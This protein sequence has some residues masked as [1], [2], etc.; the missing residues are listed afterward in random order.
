MRK[1]IVAVAA[2]LAVAIGV[3]AVVGVGAQTPTPSTTGTPTKVDTYIAKLAAELGIDQQQL[4]TA[5]L[6]A[7]LGLVDDAQAAGKITADQATQQKQ[8]IQDNNILL[9][10]FGRHGRGGPGRDAM[11]IGAAAAKVLNLDANTLTT[12]IKSGQSLAEIAQ[13]Q[14]MN[15]GDFKAAL[16]AEVKTDLDAKVSAG[17][18]TQDRAD[19]AYQNVSDNID[20]IINFKPGTGMG[21]FGFGHG[22][23]L[24]ARTTT[25][26]LPPAAAPA[27]GRR[28]REP[29]LT[30]Q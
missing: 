14:N 22:P 29:D 25:P 9:P 10:G 11:F 15:A 23:N 18:I 5:M 24:T 26:A 27:Q 19:K 4:R 20:N 21:G 8:R 12:D 7:N 6:N 17:T 1:M 28:R 16:L 30:T 2:L 3:I 13:A